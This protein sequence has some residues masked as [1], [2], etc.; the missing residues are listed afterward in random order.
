MLS[1]QLNASPGIDVKEAGRPSD[2][3]GESHFARRIEE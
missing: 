2:T 1:G 3:T